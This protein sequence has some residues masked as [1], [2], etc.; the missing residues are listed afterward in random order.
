MHC[1]PHPRLH[2]LRGYSEVIETIRWGLEKLGHQV[3]YAVNNL[4]SAATNIIFGAQMLPLD[5]L[6]QLPPD[7][8]IY[9]FEQTRGLAPEQIRDEVLYIAKAFRVW[10]YSA[11]NLTA[12]HEIGCKYVKIVPIGYAPILTKIHKPKVQDIEVLFFGMSGEKRLSAFHDLST[13]GLSTVFVSGM[14]G[15]ARDKLI[16]RAKLVLNVNLYDVSRIFEIARVSYLLANKKAVIS[17]LDPETYI[18]EDIKDGIKFSHSETLVADCI[19]LLEQDA[20][21]L[22]YEQLGFKLFSNRDIRKILDAALC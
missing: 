3:S 4:N 6:R 10:E 19:A 22:R 2:G 13:A 7:T 5:Y 17:M 14:Y 11:A 21:R 20:E 8:I 15:E 12:W 18:E 16:A 9:N 1:Q